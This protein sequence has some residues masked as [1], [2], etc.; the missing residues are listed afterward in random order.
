MANFMLGADEIA[1][2]A[3]L[4]VALR[5]GV[6]SELLK[7]S[8]G[9]GASGS[10]RL[11]AADGAKKEKKNAAVAKQEKK[12]VIDL[13]KDVEYLAKPDTLEKADDTENIGKETVEGREDLESIEKE[14]RSNGSE[15]EILL[16]SEKVSNAEEER[17]EVDLLSEESID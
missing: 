10:F 6:K 7:Q 17:E 11:G 4:K 14:I 16:P 12:K 1:V 5:S 8:T 9:S 3:R 2:N 13:T 15:K